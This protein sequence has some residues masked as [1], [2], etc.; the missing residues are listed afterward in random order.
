VGGAAVAAAPAKVKAPSEIGGKNVEEIITSWNAELV[1]RSVVPR[2][3]AKR[4][5]P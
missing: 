5:A 2:A 1:R 3:S 4:A